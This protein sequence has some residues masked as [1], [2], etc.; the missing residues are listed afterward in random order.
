M[1]ADCWHYQPQPRVVFDGWKAQVLALWRGRGGSRT[2]YRA[3]GNSRPAAG[4]GGLAEVPAKLEPEERKRIRMSLHPVQ[5]LSSSPLGAMLTIDNANVLGTVGAGC[6]WSLNGLD[7]PA[8][9]DDDCASSWDA[10]PLGTNPLVRAY[11]QQQLAPLDDL[12]CACRNGVPASCLQLGRP[13]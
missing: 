5:I 9:W 1:G 4:K 10:R 6:V 12:T 7:A 2:V 8:S 3:I 13:V 11:D